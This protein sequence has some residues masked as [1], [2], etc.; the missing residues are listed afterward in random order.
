MVSANPGVQAGVSDCLSFG[1]VY[2]LR[3]Q[4]TYGRIARKLSLFVILR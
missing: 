1:M 3:V 4:K 2:I